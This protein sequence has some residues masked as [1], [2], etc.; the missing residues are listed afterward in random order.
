MLNNIQILFEKKNFFEAVHLDV[1]DCDT[2][3]FFFGVKDFLFT[4]KFK[5]LSES[6]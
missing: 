2:V 3:F 6:E 1:E 5:M 4:F